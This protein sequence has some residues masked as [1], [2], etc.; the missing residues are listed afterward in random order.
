L[1]SNDIRFQIALALIAFILAGPLQA[2][3]SAV[4]KS[5]KGANTP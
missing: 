4:Q 1:A 5:Q 2:M 3:S